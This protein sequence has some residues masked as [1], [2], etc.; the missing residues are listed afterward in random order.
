LQGQDGKV[1]KMKHLQ[2]WF[3]TL[4]ESL[5]AEGL[6]ESFPI[7]NSIAYGATFDYT[8]A[9]GTRYGHY[10]TIYRNNE[11]KYERPIHYARG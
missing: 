8:I 5:E 2:N 4:N 6:V 11:G 10:V 7:G 9:D 1:K 3:N